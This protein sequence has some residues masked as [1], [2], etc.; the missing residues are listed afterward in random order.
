M[1]AVHLVLL[2]LLMC[3][4]N[5][6]ADSS[7]ADPATWYRDSYGSLWLNEA[8]N[9]MDEMAT[10][11]A[12]EIHTHEASEDV[13]TLEFT[14]WLAGPMEE[15]KAD[16]WLSSQVSDLKVDRLNASTVSFKGSMSLVAVF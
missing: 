2:F 8:W 9:K 16:G 1:R 4:S 6:S 5:A 15:W 14:S 12:A 11:Y 7:P 13:T 10:F 3:T